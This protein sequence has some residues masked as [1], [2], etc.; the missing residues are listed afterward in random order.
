MGST[1][2]H[3]RRRSLAASLSIAAVLLGTLA[4][5]SLADSV[6]TTG[7]ATSVTSTS[8]TLHGTVNAGSTET[9]WAFQYG[10][11]TAYDQHTPIHVVASGSQQ[12]SATL[13]GLTPGTRYHFRLLAGQGSYSTNFHTGDDAT[14]TTASAGTGGTHG[15]PRFG[16]AVL[17][18]TTLTVRHGR[19]ALPFKCTGVTGGY[20]FG[21][22]TL[23]LRSKGHTLSCA[24]GIFLARAPHSHAITSNVN[25]ACVSLLKAAR[26]H[27]LG[28]SL[29]AQFLTHQ[30]Q[31]R[32]SV[33]LALG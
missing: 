20:C 18:G 5:V 23:T 27:K 30:A 32:K 17:T 1:I 28:A 14:F 13:T 12:V 29:I 3:S 21:K 31:L 15:G 9:S 25:S 10:T 8:A 11:S 26:H 4:A 24:G 6:A 33:T 19:I 22:A 2:I 16:K 7:D